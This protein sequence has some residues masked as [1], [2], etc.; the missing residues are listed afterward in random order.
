MTKPR[1]V[2]LLEPTVPD[3]S[4]I[5]VG[6]SW[7]ISMAPHLQPEDEGPIT[8]LDASQGWT[9]AQVD[10]VIHIL[11]VVLDRYQSRAL[12]EE[13]LGSETEQPKRDTYNYKVK[14]PGCAGEMVVSLGAEDRVLG[15]GLEVANGSK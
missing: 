6:Q 2:V 3:F 4:S 10:E 5:P 8:Y 12:D 9:Q 14:C 1:P 7:L 13:A 15:E 11:H